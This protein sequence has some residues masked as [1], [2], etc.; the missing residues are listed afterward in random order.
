MTTHFCDLGIERIARALAPCTL[1]KSAWTHAAHVAAALWLL[2][3]RGL[4]VGQAQ[5]PTLIRTYNEATGVPNTDTTALHAT[6]TSVS[7]RGGCAAAS[8]GR[9]A[10][11]ARAR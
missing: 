8:Q 11:R 1:P 6:I 3:E 2:R 10:S 9:R 4:A 5:M 7:R